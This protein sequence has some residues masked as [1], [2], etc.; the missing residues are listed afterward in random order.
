MSDIAEDN[1]EELIRKLST[2]GMQ[3]LIYKKYE[4][5]QYTVQMVFRRQSTNEKLTFIADNLPFHLK[6]NSFH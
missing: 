6:Y 1:K 5:Y 2:K 3:S 4:F